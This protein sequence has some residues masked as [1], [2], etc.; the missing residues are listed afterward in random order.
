MPIYFHIVYDFFHPKIV[1]LSVATE[2]IWAHRQK[3]LLS[4]TL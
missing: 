2:T 3:Y 4:G 1:E